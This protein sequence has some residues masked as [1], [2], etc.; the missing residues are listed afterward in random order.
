M[1]EPYLDGLLA[2]DL[3]L[4]VTVAAADPWREPPGTVEAKGFR[5]SAPGPRAVAL[6]TVT[7][8]DPLTAL[9]SNR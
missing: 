8:A 4:T 7:H 3:A 2:L 6:R 5:A 9:G 1:R